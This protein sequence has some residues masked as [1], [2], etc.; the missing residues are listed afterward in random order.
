MNADATVKVATAKQT[1]KKKPASLDRKKARAGWWFVLPFVVVFIAVYIPIIF[2]SIRFSFHELEIQ[3]SGGY[4]L[5]YIGLDNYTEALFVDSGYV[6]TLI[7]GLKQLVLDIPA[8]VI[9]SLFMAIML[10]DKMPGRTLFRAIFFIPVILSTGIIDSIDQSNSMMDYMG[11][12][13]GISTGAE[14]SQTTANEIISAMDIQKLFANMKV[15][16]GLVEYVVG[17][18]NDI[19]NIVNRSGVQMLIFL[20]GLQSINPAIYE[21]CRIDGASAWETFWK[22]TFPMISP[23]ILVNT[24][25]TVIDSFTSESNQVMSYIDNIYKSAANGQV[26]S[27]AMSWMYFLI[28]VI[29]IALVAGLLSMY[30]FYQRRD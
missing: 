23:M 28:V 1:K 22:I 4:D 12:T 2:D 20:A 30:I 27:S 9:F 5:I 7:S 14:G 29:M 15:G 13:E 21:S 8:I 6:T 10:N 18:V 19:Y 16:Q 3:S 25:Y 17:L 24:V 11:S 26:L